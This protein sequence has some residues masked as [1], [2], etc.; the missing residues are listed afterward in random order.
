MVGAGWASVKVIGPHERF[1]HWQYLPVPK[2]KNG[3]YLI[4]VR[5]DKA[6]LFAMAMAL[7]G[8]PII[9]FTLALLAEG[10]DEPMLT[11]ILSYQPLVIIAGSKMACA[12][13]A[14]LAW[15]GGEAVLRA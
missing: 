13:L 4:E 5:A 7:I 12:L 3:H 14:V 1:E 2:R 6:A 10:A 11:S 15:C 9:K 8:P